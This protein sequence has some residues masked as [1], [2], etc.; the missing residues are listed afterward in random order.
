MKN[1]ELRGCKTGKEGDGITKKGLR[2]TT[3]VGVGLVGGSTVTTVATVELVTLHCKSQ[4]IWHAIIQ[5]L[6]LFQALFIFFLLFFSLTKK[7]LKYNYC[8]FEKSSYLSFK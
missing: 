4:E 2:L 5:I 8:K 3:K 7:K 6:P 1:R